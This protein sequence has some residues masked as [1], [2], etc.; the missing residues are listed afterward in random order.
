MTDRQYNGMR[1]TQVNFTKTNG[2]RR[3]PS[4]KL[5]YILI[6]YN[7]DLLLYSS[8]QSMIYVIVYRINI[9]VN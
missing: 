8:T 2:E 5:T 7:D 6:G 9:S 4:Y 1:K 3:Q